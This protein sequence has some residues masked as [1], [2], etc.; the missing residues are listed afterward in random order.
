M[1][2]SNGGRAT[3]R[4]RE[5]PF[6]EVPLYSCYHCNIREDIFCYEKVENIP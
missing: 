1:G 6:S 4:S 3:V 5:G 2:D